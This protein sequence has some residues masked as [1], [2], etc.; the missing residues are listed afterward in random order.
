MQLASHRRNVDAAPA[1]SSGRE[2]LISV[3]AAAV[4]RLAEVCVSP[5]L[6]QRPRSVDRTDRTPTFERRQRDVALAPR[7]Y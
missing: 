1:A 2:R 6:C 5:V 7:G 3:H 4:R